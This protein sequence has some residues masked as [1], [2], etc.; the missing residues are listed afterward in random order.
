MTPEST[1]KKLLDFAG[2]AILLDIEDLEAAIE[3]AEKNLPPP[4]EPDY[5]LKRA[6]V[7]M[8]K[9]VLTYTRAYHELMIDVSRDYRHRIIH[10][11]ATADSLK[12]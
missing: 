12:R 5:S 6:D 1:V 10:A 9:K 7:E 11:D 8:A 2:Q 3:A 4:G